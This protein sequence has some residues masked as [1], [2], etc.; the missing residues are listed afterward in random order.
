MSA[1]QTLCDAFDRAQCYGDSC[2]MEPCEQCPINI[3]VTP[4]D[5]SC[6]EVFARLLKESRAEEWRGAARKF[7]GKFYNDWFCSLCGGPLE[8]GAET[9]PTCGAIIARGAEARSDGRY[10]ESVSP[11]QKNGE[12]SRDTAR[13]SL[14]CGAA[15]R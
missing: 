2:P 15:I 5:A 3:A 4:D 7:N 6:K 14:G 12:T 11:Y 13:E 8:D 9:C 10:D 1:T